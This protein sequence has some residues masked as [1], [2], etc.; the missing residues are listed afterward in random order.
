[1]LRCLRTSFVWVQYRLR[2]TV[3][4]RWE[5][6]PHRVDNTL[7]SRLSGL[8]EPPP[9]IQLKQR[10]EL[11]SLPPMKEWPHHPIFVRLS[12]SVEG[13]VSR[14]MEKQSTQ[15]SRRFGFWLLVV[16][17]REIEIHSAP[18]KIN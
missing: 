2:R 18:S 5:E 3:V 15:A 9:P 6:E 7:L 14:S 4:T 17:F 11:A 8:H 12:P 16:V 1:M 10:P 13:Q